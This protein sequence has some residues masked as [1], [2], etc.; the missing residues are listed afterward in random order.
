MITDITQV[1]A[2]DIIVIDTGCGASAIRGALEGFNIQ[3]RMHYIG[4]AKHLVSLLGSRDYL[5]K[6]II[7]SCHGDQGHMVLPELAQEL[8][9][10]MPYKKRLTSSDLLEFLN[11]KGHTVINTGCG[12]GHSEFAAS[13]LAKGSENY[14]GA[15]DYIEGNAALMFVIAFCYFYFSEG[16]T[17]DAAF[18]KAYSLDNETKLF[19]LWK[20]DNL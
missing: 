18:N 3:T 15:T 9:R 1:K 6:T 19:K 8:E 17:I 14:I 20:K 16:I 11:L 5:H 4:N 10:T 13:F 7:L 2:V 12:L